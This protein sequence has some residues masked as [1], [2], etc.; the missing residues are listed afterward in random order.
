[1]V[2]FSQS[3]EEHVSHLQWVLQCVLAAWLTIHPKKCAITKKEV[4]YLGYVIGKIKLQIGKVEDIQAFLVPTT[5]K[6]VESF[7]VL[8]G[9]TGSSF[10]TLQFCSSAVFNEGPSSL[11]VLC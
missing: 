10:P 11:L 2:L 8:L 9:G 4:K 1:M 3:C 7:M 5:K 6:K